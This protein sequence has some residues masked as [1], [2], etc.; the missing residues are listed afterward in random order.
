MVGTYTVTLTTQS[1]KGCTSVYSITDMVVVY[2]YPVANF[3]MNPQP[4]TIKNP[5]IT[6]SDLSLG[7]IKWSWDFGDSIPNDKVDISNEQNPF[8]TYN[9]PGTYFPKLVVTNKYG[10]K[11]TISLKL[12]IGNDYSIYIPNAFTPNQDRINDGFIAKG[13]GILEYEMFIFNRWGENIFTGQGLNNA[14]DGTY[15]GKSC[16]QDVYVYIIKIK[17]IFG[18]VKEFSGVVTLLR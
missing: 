8:Y 14:W 7:A 1:D 16:Q 12:I 6:F 13:E 18:D 11:D 3:T 9:T 15:K 5:K 2:P 17:T 4:T 10:C